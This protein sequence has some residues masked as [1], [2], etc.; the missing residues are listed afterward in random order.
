MQRLGQFE[1][2]PV[3][4]GRRQKPRQRRLVSKAKSVPIPLPGRYRLFTSPCLPPG[5]SYERWKR[6]F[7]L[8][9][10]AGPTTTL[11]G[12][13]LM[14]HEALGLQSAQTSRP[15]STPSRLPGQ[16]VAEPCRTCFRGSVIGAAGYRMTRLTGPCNFLGQSRVAQQ[17]CYSP[18]SVS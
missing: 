7:R 1:E 10:A 17:V 16:E 13:P 14:L 3:P 18:S 9:T 11:G 15:E 4:E 6:E 5:V 8:C 12:K 2:R